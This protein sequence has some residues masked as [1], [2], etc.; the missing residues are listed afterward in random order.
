MKI[1][2]SHEL[3]VDVQRAYEMLLDP[4]VLARALPGCDELVRIGPDEYEMRLKVAIASV[5]GL[6]SGKVRITDRQP[7]DSYRMAVEGTGRVGFVKGEGLMK[8]S[9]KEGATEMQ[10]E[11]DVQVGGMIAGV[12]QRLLE[13]SARMIIKRFMDKLS[14]EAKR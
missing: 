3:P 2:G 6:F 5:Q 10:Y 14:E 7:P 1:T 4:D 12:G 11:G 8:L 13:T 9:P